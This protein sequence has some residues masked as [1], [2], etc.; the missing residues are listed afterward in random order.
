MTADPRPLPRP[1]EGTFAADFGDETVVLVQ[2]RRQ[3]HRLNRSAAAIWRACDGA[4]DLERIT[5]RVADAFSTTPAVVAGDVRRTVATLTELGLLAADEHDRRPGAHGLDEG[6][7][8]AVEVGAGGPHDPPGSP[9]P[10]TP[11]AGDVGALETLGPYAGLGHTF[12]VRLAD[13]P[14]RRYLAHVLRELET[15]RHPAEHVYTVVSDGVLTWLL[16]DGEPRSR[17]TDD[18]RVA[19]YLEWHVNQGAIA[20]PEGS[21]VL[22]ASGVSMRGRVVAMPAPMDA[23]KSTLV[24]ALVR[25]GLDY[26]T[27]EALAFDPTSLA[28]RPY[29]K[30]VTLEPGSFAV[31][32]ELEPTDPDH[33][34]YLAD[35]WRLLPSDIRPGARVAAGT[36]VGVVSPRYQAGTGCTVEHLAPADAFLLLLENTFEASLADEVCLTALV[37]VA[38]RV[39][40]LRV[41]YSDLDEVG[42][43]VHEVLG[44][45]PADAGLLR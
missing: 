1:A 35:R 41:V 42:A 17:F 8:S 27:D 37:R 16:V 32:P 11:P 12:V 29:P 25:R 7:A 13:G 23:G 33:L 9:P 6:G 30:A 14:L 2:A 43:V 4:S 20:S 19:A 40:C 24:T 3:A 45:R 22:H 26:V 28:V 5:E 44:T 10:G 34:P 39:P 31:F 15:D 18:T 36:L 21:V 38:R